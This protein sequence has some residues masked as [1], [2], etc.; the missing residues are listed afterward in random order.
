M[1]KTAVL[2]DSFV[3]PLGADATDGQ[4]TRLIW[5]A[6]SL[7]DGDLAD[8]LRDELSG[9]FAGRLQRFTVPMAL[10]GTTFQ[11]AF[12][13]ALCD[14]PFGQTRTY[15]AL[16]RQLGVSAQAIG[17]ACG[18]NPLPILVPCHRVLG[19]DTLGGYSGP[20]GVEGKVALL[21]LEGA[22]GLLI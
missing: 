17:Q 22:G 21:R 6:G 3:G 10:P 2:A 19:A 1:R 12:L 11:Q 14:I 9:Y 4:I 16:A 18:A 7:A 13:R 8:H 20:G 5:G 15:G